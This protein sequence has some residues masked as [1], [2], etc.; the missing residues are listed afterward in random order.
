MLKS[1]EQGRKCQFQ[2]VKKNS[3]LRE[4]TI[5]V[6]FLAV[7]VTVQSLQSTGRMR[8]EISLVSC[9]SVLINLVR[10]DD[11]VSCTRMR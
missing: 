4:R 11:E 5:V 10:Q 3:T 2:E 7:R 6:G 8:N 9:I 1:V